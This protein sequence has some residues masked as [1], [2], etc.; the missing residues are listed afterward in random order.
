VPLPPLSAL[1]L[2]FDMSLDIPFL[3]ASLS[4]LEYQLITSVAA[5]NFAGGLPACLL[6]VCCMLAWQLSTARC[7]HMACCA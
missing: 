7:T 4:D 6:H 1:L 2:Q 5:D 3:R